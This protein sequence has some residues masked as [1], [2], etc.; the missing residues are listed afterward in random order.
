MMALIN[1]EN[2]KTKIKCGQIHERGLWWAI[3]K[4]NFRKLYK[5]N[6]NFKV[7]NINM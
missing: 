1:D 5:K 3:T 2:N 7:L 4:M 6:I